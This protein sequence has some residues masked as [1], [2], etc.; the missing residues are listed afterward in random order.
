V[1]DRLAGVRAES[2]EPTHSRVLSDLE[3]LP[4]DAAIDMAALAWRHSLR[5]ASLEVG[6]LAA[7]TQ[8]IEA[9]AAAEPLRGA[10]LAVRLLDALDT[11]KV[12]FVALPEAAETAV[13]RLVHVAVLAAGQGHPDQGVL[14]A[15]VRMALEGH[16]Q[17]AAHAAAALDVTVQRAPEVLAAVTSLVLVW[18]AQPHAEW[19]EVSAPSGRDRLFSGLIAAIAHAAALDQAMALAAVWPPMR[20]ALVVLATAL[21]AQGRSDDVLTLAAHYDARGESWAAC[22]SAAAEAARIQGQPACSARLAAY[23]FDRR[24]GEMWFAMLAQ[25]DGAADWPTR[26][27]A[28]VTRLLADDDPAWLPARLAAEPDAVAALLHAILAAPLRDRSTSGGLVLLR[29]LDAHAAFRGRCVRLRAMATSPG[30][31]ARPF[32]DELGQLEIDAEKLR[33][34][35]LFRDFARLLARECSDR[36]PLVTAV[37]SVLGA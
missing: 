37:R 36:A 9:M 16:L 15:L 18:A 31:T 2:R 35:G 23:A 3:R 17:T 21:G 8:R 27:M 10:Q 7:A 4:L 28:A 25:A 6:Q 12:V 13:V 32:R 19:R 20:S 29:D 14:D 26:R 34:P 11:R 22:L 30:L 5:P 24:P 1:R 33:E